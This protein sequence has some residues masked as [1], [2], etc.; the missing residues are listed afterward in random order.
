MYAYV[1]NN[2]TSLTDPSGLEEANP[3]STAQA[4]QGQAAGDSGGS[5]PKDSSSGGSTPAAAAAVAI[6]IVGEGTL[7]ALV[8]PVAAGIVLGA[9]L[10]YLAAETEQLYD[11]YHLSS[12]SGGEPPQLQAGKEAH[13]NEEVRPGE[14][15]EVPTPSGSG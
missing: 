11:A 9:A 12:D 4:A 10:G 13:A 2:P 1:R 8:P 15:A 6:G 3:G 14:K 7:A 5:P